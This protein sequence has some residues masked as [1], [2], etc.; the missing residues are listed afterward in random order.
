MLLLPMTRFL[1]YLWFVVGAMAHG[2]I[3]VDYNDDFIS[4]TVLPA[5]A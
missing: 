4:R 1:S 5:Y 3:D 2:K